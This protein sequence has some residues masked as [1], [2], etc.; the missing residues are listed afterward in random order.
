M[1]L[2]GF[3][4]FTAE[5]ATSADVDSYLMQGI[6]V[7]ATTA[8]RDSALSGFLEE[9]RFCYITGTN[10]I[11]YYDGSAWVPFSTQWTSFTPAWTG[12]TVG[13]GTQQASYRYVAGDM[14]VRVLVNCGSTTAL[15]GN[16]VMDIPNSETADSGGGLGNGVI[17]NDDASRP[18]FLVIDILPATQELIFYYANET[19]SGVVTTATPFILAVD[20]RI[21][22]DVVIPVA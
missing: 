12:L 9:G 21:R 8:A 2:G 15:T 6:L 4:D 7:F 10:A 11:Y 18:Y 14:R 13:N 17:Y 16:L 20:D 5:V 19:T 3:K 22:I 1:A